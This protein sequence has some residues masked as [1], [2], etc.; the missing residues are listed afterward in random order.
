MLI[1]VRFDCI[2]HYPLI[3]IMI[4]KNALEKARRL[5]FIPTA[6]LSF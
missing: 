6:I 4:F 5:Y 2:K 3:D 1:T